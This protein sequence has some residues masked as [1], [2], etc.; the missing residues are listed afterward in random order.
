AFKTITSAHL[1]SSNASIRIAG[2][3]ELLAHSL[4]NRRSAEELESSLIDHDSGLEVLQNKMAVTP[5]LTP[6]INKICSG[7][8]SEV[9][10][11]RECVGNLCPHPNATG[12]GPGLSCGG[13]LA[14]SSSS[15]QTARKTTQEFHNLNIQLQETEQ[16]IRAAEMASSKIQTNAQNLRNQMSTVRTQIEADIQRIQQFIRQVRNFLSDPDTDA[17]TI[18]QVSNYILSLRLPTDTGTIL[19]KVTEIQNL[20]AKLQCP[21]SIIAQTA[22]DIAKAKQLQQEA[23]EARNQ[24]STIEGNVDDVLQKLKQASTALQEAEHTIHASAFP[25]QRIQSR[26]DEIQTILTP[27]QENVRDITNQLDSFTERLAQLQHKASQN[28]LL[29]ADA[30]QQATEASKQAKSTQQVFEQLKGKYT[31]LKRQATQR[32]NLGVQGARIQSAHTEANTLLKEA[33]NMM[34]KMGALET[35]IRESN[36]VFILKSTRLEGLEKKV[37]TI[38]NHISQRAAYYASCTD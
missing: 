29:A 26:L 16:M 4:E 9:C 13:I 27:A 10:T 22:G 37:E 6:V 7:V 11:P 21:D 15:I 1:T 36:N 14:L 3:S 19:S 28:Q 33:L 32:P 25:L 23:E 2:S 30:Q 20:I 12:C 34:S 31:E 8:R 38:R 5:N 18:Q 24:A 35:E 17:T